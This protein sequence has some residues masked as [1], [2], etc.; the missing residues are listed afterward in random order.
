MALE[1]LVTALAC[2]STTTNATSNLPGKHFSVIMRNSAEPF[3]LTENVGMAAVSRL[4]LFEHTLLVSGYRQLSSKHFGW[5][6]STV[7]PS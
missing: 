4:L 3:L 1:A 2:L 5:L 7:S 6:S